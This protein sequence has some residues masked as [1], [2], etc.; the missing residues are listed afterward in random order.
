LILLC[1]P[2]PGSAG[3]LVAEL[4]FAGYD[5]LIV[6]GKAER[7]SVLVIFDQ[8]VRLDDAKDLWGRNAF[9]TQKTSPARMGR[10]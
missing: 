10:E 1:R 3:I 7:P 6:Q 9:E 5:G 8:K 4:K 2:D